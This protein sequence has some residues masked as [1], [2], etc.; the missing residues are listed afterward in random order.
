M[1]GKRT[2][3]YRAGQRQPKGRGVAA[4]MRSRPRKPCGA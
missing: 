3:Q 2:K 4:G 1:T